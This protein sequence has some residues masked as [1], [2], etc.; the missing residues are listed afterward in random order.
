MP[1][2]FLI[3]SNILGKYKFPELIEFKKESVTE[4]SIDNV[5]K[6]I[7]FEDP[8]YIP[9]LLSIREDNALLFNSKD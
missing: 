1:P 3:A 7:G 5:S 6:D 4:E 8:E 9:N 2:P